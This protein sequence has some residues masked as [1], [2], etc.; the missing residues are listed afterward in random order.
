MHTSRKS[1]LISAAVALALGTSLAALAQDPAPPK[2]AQPAPATPTI[3]PPQA[4]IPPAGAPAAAQT[5]ASALKAF[6]E[7][8]KDAKESDGFF[9]VFQKDEKTWIEIE[10]EQLD[11]PFY[12]STVRTQGLG[13]KRI[14]AGL[15]GD[16]HVVYFKKIGN[17]VQLI[18]QNLRFRAKEGTPVA[19]AVERSYSDSLLASAPVVSQPHP[20]SKAILIEA[21]ALMLSDIPGASTDLERAFRLPYALDSR[22]SHLVKAKASES[23]TGF[24]V[25]LHFAVPKLPAPPLE[26]PA[27]PRTP[28]PRNTPDAR[29]LFLGYYYNFSKLPEPMKPRIADER[30]G[31]F[32][33]SFTDYADE[34]RPEPR[35]HYVNRWRLEKK[36]PGAALSE[37]V[38]PIVYWVDKNIPER[39]R[40]AVVDGILEWNKAF[41]K[42][43]FKDA[44]QAKL[45]P[46]NADFDTEDVR[47][48]TI[49]WYLTSENG[50]AIGPSHADPR[51]G[52]ILDAD[53]L[54]TDGFA[55]SSRRFIVDDVPRPV[56][57][58]AHNSMDAYCNYSDAA[59]A[60]MDFAM[61]LLEARGDIEPG[62]PEAEAFVLSYIK[63]VITHEVGHTLGLRHNFRSSTVYTPEQLRD[64]DFTE[65]NGIV[66]S[67]MDYAPFNIPVNG[68]KRASYV[69]ST[70]GPY[71]YWA[72]EYAYKPVEPAAEKEE[73]E[74][75]AARG[76]KESWLAY[77]TDEDG[78]GV[79]SPQGM[80][81]TVNTFD[82]SSNP[83]AFYRKRLDL[84]RE[85]WD[86]VQK[87]TL[88]PGETYDSVR[89][90]FLAGFTQLSRGLA[91]ATKYIGGIVQVRDRAGTGRTPFTP[92][93][94]TQQREALKLISEGAFSV[95]S[96]RFKPEFLASLPHNRLDYFDHLERGNGATSPMVSVPQAVLGMQKTVLD[97][98]MSDGVA[99][100][101][102]DS[103]NMTAKPKEAFT[104]GELYD[105]LQ[106]SI[107]SEL[108]SGR[109]ITPMRR[110]LQR[111]HLRRVAGALLRPTASLPADARSLHRLNAQ[112]LAAEI[113]AAHA[114]PAFSKETKA[115]LAESLNTLDEALKATMVR[116][117]A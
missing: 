64:K 99:N 4:P 102:V 13:E 51:T 73:L 72:I 17:H 46:D 24:E 10:P 48:A 117:G 55:R 47:H 94:A 92:V 65:K 63:N 84:S 83:L 79:G 37:P 100:R 7:V 70:I 2:P 105:T 45:Q 52:E 87:K 28:P 19:R 109:E 60:E 77:A 61:D 95:D 97:Q 49:R 40:Q 106:G 42:I 26:P 44:I 74:K 78:W 75:I 16:T 68:E 90:S 33:T 76:S 114:K 96:F 23:N 98:V 101:L 62:S 86:R 6:K 80:D 115:H 112:A 107:W 58:H 53:I 88:N 66:G 35:T 81:P 25:S 21:G 39:Y 29:S 67:V 93:P 1:K 3:N 89:R 43:G 85:L 103:Q 32:T 91:P 8:V 22:N 27:T 14:Y 36:D 104:L 41:E 57:S 108:K 59:A 11:K 82:L 30:V 34:L 50:P 54:M 15:M 111:E 18:A 113:R 38:K 110:N 12:F 56:T 20:D 9:K 31:Y 71:D 69:M 116:Q 5:P